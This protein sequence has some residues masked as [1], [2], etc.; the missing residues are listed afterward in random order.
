MAWALGAIR[1]DG[2]EARTLSAVRRARDEAGYGD[3]T[4]M[5]TFAVEEAD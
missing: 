2:E 4:R 5:W 1:A 3:R